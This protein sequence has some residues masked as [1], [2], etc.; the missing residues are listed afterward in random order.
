MNLLATLLAVIERLLNEL[1]R[2][3]KKRREK[4][5]KA[6]VE[7]IKEDSVDYANKHFGGVHTP[8]EEADNVPRDKAD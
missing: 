5:Y 8:A 6:D 1:V 2:L 7:A 3:R 4:E